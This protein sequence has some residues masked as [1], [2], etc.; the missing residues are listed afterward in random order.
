MF[1]DY[2]GLPGRLA[3]GPMGYFLSKIK[4]HS[5]IHSFIHTYLLRG[6]GRVSWACHVVVVSSSQKEVMAQI[7]ALLLVTAHVAV[8]QN[9]V[10]VVWSVD[11][12]AQH[13]R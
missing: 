5:F 13:Q 9:Q 12:V 1:V 6:R 4:I 10:R 8:C 7:I 11:G 2:T 3:R